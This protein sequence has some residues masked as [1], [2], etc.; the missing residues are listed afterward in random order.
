VNAQYNR[1][2]KYY[3]AKLAKTAKKKICPF[4][5]LGALGVLARVSLTC[6]R[7]LGET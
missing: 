6:F 3:R 1:C 2:K 7:N 4:S 5:E